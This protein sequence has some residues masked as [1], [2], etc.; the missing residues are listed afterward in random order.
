MAWRAGYEEFEGRSLAAVKSPG[1]FDVS[2][3]PAS[4]F[5]FAQ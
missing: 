5:S 4:P 3:G 1:L 2:P